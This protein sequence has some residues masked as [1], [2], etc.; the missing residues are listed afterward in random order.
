MAFGAADGTRQWCGVGAVVD[1]GSTYTAKRLLINSACLFHMNPS[2]GNIVKRAS[3]SSWNSSSFTL[4]FTVASGNPTRMY[5]LLI[6]GDD[7]NARVDTGT[8]PTST[9][10]Q[11]YT[12]VANGKALITWNGGGITSLNSTL[13]HLGYGIGFG[14]ENGTYS[15]SLFVQDAANTVAWGQSLYAIHG[16]NSTGGTSFRGGALIHNPGGASTFR[17]NWSIVQA[18]AYYFGYIHLGGAGLKA[19]VGEQTATSSPNSVNLVDQS[20]RAVLFSGRGVS[21]TGASSGTGD[22]A[23]SVGYGD[24]QVIGT[25]NTCTGVGFAASAGGCSSFNGIPQAQ[26]ARVLAHDTNGDGSEDNNVLMNAPDTNT[27]FKYQRQFANNSFHYLSLGVEPFVLIQKALSGASGSSGG[28][29]TQRTIVKAL[30]GVSVNSGEVSTHIFSVISQLLTGASTSAGNVATQTLRLLSLSGVSS[31]SG[32]VVKK[33]KKVL[34][35]ASSNAGE[36]ATEI[37]SIFR[38][39]LEWVDARV[40]GTVKYLV[41]LSNKPI[42]GVTPENHLFEN[43]LVEPPTFTRGLLDQENLIS[44]LSETNIRFNNYDGLFKNKGN[45]E[46]YYARIERVFAALKEEI[47]GVVTRYIRGIEIEAQ[48][49]DQEAELEQARFPRRLTSLDL[50]PDLPDKDAGKPIVPY[51]GRNIKVPCLLIKNDIVN[52]EFDYLIG[53][54]EGI[55]GNLKEAT[56]AY[57][58]NVVFEDYEGAVQGVSGSAITLESQEARR[59]EYYRFWFVQL[60]DPLDGAVLDEKYV[61]TYDGAT[62]RVTPDS[63][64]AVSPS[65]K[66]YRIKPWRFLDGSQSTPYGGFGVLRFKINMT[67]RG[68]LPEIYVD[69]DGLQ[70]EKN[71]VRAIQ[72]ILSNNTWGFGYTV[73]G[74]TFDAL[75]VDAGITALDTEGGVKERVDATE[76]LTSLLEYREMRL[77][78]E[79]GVVKIDADAPSSSVDTFRLGTDLPDNIIAVDSGGVDYGLTR[80]K[81]KALTVVYRENNKESGVW[82]GEQRGDV[83]SRGHDETLTLPW[84]YAHESAN[85]ELYY[86]IARLISASETLTITVNEDGEGLNI[87]DVITLDLPQYG[88][89]GDWEIREIERGNGAYKLT[90]NPDNQARFVYE[91]VGTLP[92]DLTEAIATDFSSTPPAQ[93]TGLTLEQGIEVVAGIPYPYAIL[94]WTVPEENYSEAVISINQTGGDVEDFFE[95]GKG[96][97]SFKVGGGVL[98]PGVPYD[99]LVEPV[100]E[101]GTEKGEGSSLINQVAGGDGTTPSPPSGLIGSAGHADLTWS[102]NRVSG[103]TIRGYWLEV[104]IASSGGSHIHTEF[105]EQPSSGTT[106]N[107]KPYKA[108][109]GV[110]TNNI[111]RYAQVKTV[112]FNGKESA[113]TSRAGATTKEII[114]GDLEDNATYDMSVV[115]GVSSVPD[116]YTIGTWMEVISAAPITLT[117]TS[118]IKIR[119]SGER[120]YTGFGGNRLRITRNG[121]QRYLYDNI[122]NDD[123]HPS[124]TFTEIVGPGTYS[125][126][127]EYRNDTS[128]GM[129]QGLRNRSLSVQSRVK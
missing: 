92:T 106:V 25:R 59:N 53:E 12:G 120:E 4:N 29:S 108:Q 111:T 19:K 116:P 14:G 47:A 40:D 1:G 52:S 129:G 127:I 32:S 96:V 58:G 60:T 5:Y 86:K 65:G 43:R 103:T 89:D 90:L 9:G 79:G 76:V 38:M 39:A 80:D 118:Y 21:L 84:A 83:H 69:L 105:I 35:G 57:N 24:P 126:K 66:N 34:E 117:Q 81:I 85:R 26:N 16:V 78:K 71:R 121:S 37:T 94:R 70:G 7:F 6:G 48:V 2:N 75:A 91:Q 77:R 13:S 104:Y 67:K 87:R 64:W 46:G 42:T 99:Y 56:A 23:L 63:A 17:L 15:R 61:S 55:S 20:P 50:F 54:A 49:S 27:D 22:E 10:N 98:Q 115:S 119:F 113:F 109:T 122:A 112:K 68:S 101:A 110:L 102:F 124:M 44:G 95:V 62:N 97:S 41:T 100:N 51:F 31:N 123:A 11:D 45:L 73:D 82:L 3:L 125:Y 128:G 74:T 28:V 36:V 107:S 30:S 72:S 33:I 93:V 88:I 18:S 8:V 114:R